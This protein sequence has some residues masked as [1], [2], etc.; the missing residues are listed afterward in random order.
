[1]MT[2]QNRSSAAIDTR[3]SGTFRNVKALVG[4]Y[5][6]VSVAN[7]IA[8]VLLRNNVTMVNDA[9]WVRSIIVL[10]SALLTLSFVVR[11]ARG[12]RRA[13]LRLRLVSAVM[14]VA[15]AV[16]IAL[17]GTFPTWLKIEQGVCGLLLLGVVALVNGKALRSAFAAK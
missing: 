12:S 2:T 8:I 3:H 13:F 9:V 1:M 14:T 6:G 10:A 7:V 15:I 17:P 4:T 5:L 16:I 11:A